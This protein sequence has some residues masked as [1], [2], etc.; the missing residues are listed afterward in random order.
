M[1]HGLGWVQVLTLSGGDC[2]AGTSSEARGTHTYMYRDMM[3]ENGG[4]RVIG[5]CFD[6]MFVRWYASS[7]RQRE[8]LPVVHT[9]LTLEADSEHPDLLLLVSTATACQLLT[10]RVG[11]KQTKSYGVSFKC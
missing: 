11:T 2:C 10:F 1:N 6:T 9:G 8:I 3:S 7:S 4:G 5:T